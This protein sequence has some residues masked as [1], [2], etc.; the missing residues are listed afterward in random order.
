MIDDIPKRAIIDEDQKHLNGRIIGHPRG[1]GVGGSTTIAYNV[2]V[3]PSQATINAWEKLGNR[4]WGWKDMC[5]YYR[6]FHTLYEPIA[7]TAEDLS[8]AYLDKSIRG[9]NGPI[10]VSFP[11]EDFYGPLHKAWPQTFR[12]LDM[13][14]TGDPA[15]GKMK[16][17]FTNPCCVNPRSKMRSYAGN[18][19]YNPEVAK[20][21]NLQFLTETL[22]EKIRFDDVDRQTATGVL[23]RTVDGNQQTAHARKEVIVC[24]GAIQSPQL[25]ELS[26]IG[27]A[28]R[29]KALGITPVAD[30]PYVGENLQDHACA[31][32]SFE[33]IEGISTVEDT[34]IPGKL[35]ELIQAYQNTLS[36]P[37]TASCISSAYIPVNDLSILG[38]HKVLQ[39]ILDAELEVKSGGHPALQ[40]QYELQRAIVE[41]TNDSTIHYWM[42]NTQLCPH[43]GPRPTDWFGMKEDGRYTVID[44]AL[45]NP[46][47]R[48]SVHIKSADPTAKPAIDP[49]YL[50]NKLDLELLARHVLF[51][52]TIVKTEPFSSLIKQDGRR[53]PPNTRLHTL[54]E[55]RQFVRDTVVSN[56]HP[57][58]TCAMLPQK[59]GGVVDD[60]LK[61]YGT[62]NVRVCDA[63]IFP[64]IPRGNIQTSVYATAEKGA[65]LIKGVV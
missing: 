12:N 22:A 34:K 36:G 56:Y 30:N 14:Y 61:V 13:G 5:C 1:K 10:Q 26:G 54:E 29:L 49:M 52:E 42:L 35:D 41:D 47:S 65:D 9:A 31:G 2:I 6:K 39:P 4:G 15:T 55:A 33:V 25:L 44:A 40:K 19:Y 16:G 3:F 50:S 11:N 57:A 24:A 60:R 63:S 51:I 18:A 53:V 62:K 23:F 46:F 43:T 59:L 8:L 38:D 48:G 21:P 17:G 64:L 58:C 32:I 45:T 7:K 27:D 28:K 20:R 37:L